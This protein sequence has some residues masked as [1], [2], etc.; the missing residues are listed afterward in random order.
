MIDLGG[1]FNRNLRLT[2]CGGGD[3]VLRVYRPWVTAGRLATLRAIRQRLA[4]HGLPIPQPLPLD[5][6]QLAGPLGARLAELEPFVASDGGTDSWARANV[7]AGLLGQLHGALADWRPPVPVVPPRVHTALPEATLRRW[8]LRTGE[9]TR[10]GIRHARRDEA[11]ATLTMAGRVLDAIS[12][13]EPVPVPHQLT[14]GDYG[15][16]NLRFRCGTP[17]ALLDLDFAGVRPRVADLADLAF[18]PHWMPSFGQ[19]GFP[20][21]RRDWSRV[22]DLIRHY[23]AAI[24][25]PLS[26]E[27]VTAL[28]VLMT[29]LPVAW[30]AMGWLIADPVSAVADLAGE[31]DTAAWLLTHR[32]E[33]ARSWQT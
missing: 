20:P 17:V 29:R 18:S 25:Q 1:T 7:A 14:H 6:G 31:L 15:H 2:G 8:L 9:V 28:P 24:G 26:R 4:D 13:V 27:E 12:A 11:M 10:A 22:R 32:G 30:A 23:D 5:H 21:G 33:L 19:L 3:V 16:D